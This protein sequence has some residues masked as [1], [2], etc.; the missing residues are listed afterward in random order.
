M[1]ILDIPIITRSFA[2]ADLSIRSD[3]RTIYGLA[4]PF[5]SL[6]SIR[7]SEG[8]Y[9]EQFQFGAF[10][11][12]INR[13]ALHR[14][15]LRMLHD[16]SS[17]SGVAVELREDAAGLVAAMR[18]SKTQRGDEMLELVRDGA[19]D[20]FSVGFRPVKTTWSDLGG[21]SGVRTSPA[22]GATATRTEVQ[23]L[24][25]SVVDFAAY[26]DALIGGVRY[27]SDAASPVEPGVEPGPQPI[28]PATPGASWLHIQN[29]RAF[30]QRL[31]HSTK[32]K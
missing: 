20:Q 30:Q 24:E 5:D 26:D 14:V 19:F 28:E 1:T 7:D 6:T 9:S 15:K 23:L 11:H 16:K 32:E 17:T 27:T 8:D 25:I 22:R 2:D 12:T 31:A 21:L 29:V 10:S 18:V 13:G 3:G 4:V